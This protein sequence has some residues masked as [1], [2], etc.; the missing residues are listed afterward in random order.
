MIRNAKCAFAAVITGAAEIQ[1]PRIERW[2][3][4]FR[5][6]IWQ[7]EN[8]KIGHLEPNNKASIWVWYFVTSTSIYRI[9]NT[10]V[11]VFS[12]RY[13]TQWRF[14]QQNPPQCI[15]VLL[16]DFPSRLLLP[17]KTIV[18]TRGFFCQ[19][20][21]FWININLRI[22]FGFFDGKNHNKRFCHVY[23]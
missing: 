1:K 15:A 16:E 8:I 21:K 7:I 22:E 18:K 12:T 4:V 3:S 6:R 11:C 20:E 9:S 5:P 13:F 2:D 14:E 19:V 17:K 10:H 23:E